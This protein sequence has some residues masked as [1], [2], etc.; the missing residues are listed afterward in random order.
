MKAGTVRPWI[1][2]AVVVASVVAVSTASSAVEGDAFV[3]TWVL[4]VAKSKYEPGPGP[5]NQTVTYEATADGLKITVNGTQADGTPLMVTYTGK[6]DGKD[7]PSTGNP[8]WDMQSLKLVNPK[9][10]E[11]TRKKG[12]KVVQ[13]ATNVVSEDG[14]TR[15]ITMT[16]VDEKGQKTT[17]VAVYDKK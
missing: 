16:G 1:V 4:N 8:D 17:S 6:L 3:G 9:T 2:V 15:T 13:T 5:K 10:M 12:G 11:I 7:Y 14:K